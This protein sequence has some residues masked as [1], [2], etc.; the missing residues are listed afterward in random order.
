MKNTQNLHIMSGIEC[1]ILRQ[2]RKSIAILVSEGNVIIKA[3]LRT[4]DATIQKFVTQKRNWIINK[5]DAYFVKFHR[6]KNI[7]ELKELT[8]LGHHYPHFYADIKKITFDGLKFAIPNNL[9]PSL[10]GNEIALQNQPSSGVT[11]FSPQKKLTAVVKKFYITFAANYLYRYLN[12]I[13]AQ[14]NIAYTQ[15]SLTNAKTKW[16]SCDAKKHIRL[17]WRLVLLPQNLINYV[18]IHELCHTYYLNH[19]QNYY[20]TLQSYCPNYKHLKKELK[21]WNIIINYLSE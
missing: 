20:K 18:I 21:E 13:S 16:G 2:R 17:N 19:S 3:P 8:L 6:F 4:T 1:Q 10:D 7:L 12:Q 15:F 11:K 9:E 5:I 14:L